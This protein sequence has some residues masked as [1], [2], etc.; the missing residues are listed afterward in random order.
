[1]HASPEEQKVFGYFSIL[2]SPEHGYFGGYLI[3]SPLGRPLEFHCT[4]PVRPSRAQ[5]I[6]Y[7]PTLR[8]YVVGDQIAG[9]L[10][11]AAQLTPRLV[12]TDQPEVVSAKRS[13]EMSFVLVLSRQTSENEAM[14]A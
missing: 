9:A 8:S 1:M 2:Q 6:L 7:G 13:S 4:A 11:G 3:V 14:L 10:L 12:L 5:E